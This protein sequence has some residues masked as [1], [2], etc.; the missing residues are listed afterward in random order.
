M[1]IN[2]SSIVRSIVIGGVGLPVALGFSG[3]LNSA[4]HYLKAGAESISS[5]N[6][7]VDSQNNVKADLTKD[8]LS[9]LLSK[10]DSKLE[11]DA[12]DEVDEYFGGEVSHKEVCNWV[13][14]LD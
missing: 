8:C 13:I 5:E 6:A 9:Y 2:I 14:S 1:E 12:K 11:R 3:I 7:R 4:S 10:N